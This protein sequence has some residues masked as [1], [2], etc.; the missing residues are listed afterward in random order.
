MYDSYI[1]LLINYC[2]FFHHQSVIGVRKSCPQIWHFGTLSILSR[3][4]RRKQLKQKDL[5]GGLLFFFW[6]S[7][8][9]SP[10]AMKKTLWLSCPESS[11]PSVTG[12]L[13]SIQRKGMKGQEVQRKSWTNTPCYIPFSLLSVAYT[14]SPPCSWIYYMQFWPSVV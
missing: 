7:P 13:P 3:R 9:S 2:L 14:V 8:T 1:C 12:I 10:K 11:Q 5:F 6:L 4:T